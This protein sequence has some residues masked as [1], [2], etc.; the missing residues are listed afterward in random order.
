MEVPLALV[1]VTILPPFS[2]SDNVGDDDDAAQLASGTIDVDD[3]VDE[4]D[5]STNG[6]TG[7]IEDDDSVEVAEDGANVDALATECPRPLNSHLLIT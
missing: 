6:E 7:A 3:N 4:D 5:G 2:A 1:L